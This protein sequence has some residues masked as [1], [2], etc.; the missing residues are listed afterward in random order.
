MD[1]P[2]NSLKAEDVWPAG[3][4]VAQ[5]DAL[6]ADVRWMAGRK[7][8]FVE[9]ACPACNG[10]S[11]H[12]PFTKYGMRYVAC[13]SC[14]T[15]YISPRPP[16]QLLA[17]FYR[18]SRN[19]QF[20]NDHIFPATEA[21]R[22]AKIFR[23]RVQRLLDLCERHAVKGRTLLEV[24]AG[25]GTFCEELRQHGRFDR[26][27]GVEL[28][29]DLAQTCRRRGIDVIEKPIEEI[30]PD[31]VK[32]DVLASFEVIEHL[33]SPAS[34]LK[35]CA[36]LL[37][38]QGLLVLTCPNG[39]GFDVTMLGAGSMVIDHEHLNYFNPQ[40]LAL[41]AAN[42][43]FEV[44]EVSTPGELDAEL[45]HAEAL[46]G[47]LDLSAQP[48]LSTVLVERWEELGGAFQAFLKA[49]KLSSH[50]WLVAR[51]KP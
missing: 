42:C 38:P 30:D 1:E 17:E 32:V 13:D 39:L 27:L 49:G 40:S 51:R 21:S 35:S 45:V 19:Y 20:Y 7:D 34:F 11:G 47:R 48:F 29:P 26:I 33:F 8:Q 15:I 44:L 37:N 46:A 3:L 18:Q 5:D 25:Y 12:E 14:S 50:M 4:L 6:L 31:S 23:P 9:V 36:K 28:T 22:R 24:G 16:A 43:G 2:A 41:L 10:T